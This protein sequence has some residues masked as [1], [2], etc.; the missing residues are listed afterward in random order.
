MPFAN[1]RRSLPATRALA[2]SPLESQILPPGHLLS[3]LPRDLQR[4]QWDSQTGLSVTTINDPDQPHQSTLSPRAIG[5][6]ANKED[7][8]NGGGG[9]GG[10]V[11]VTGVSVVSTRSMIQGSMITF[12]DVAYVVPVKKTPCTKAIKKVVLDG[13]R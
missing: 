4:G 13:V 8:H 2:P 9:G 7:N 10:D 3:A 1:P 6:K 5:G 11:S 12:R